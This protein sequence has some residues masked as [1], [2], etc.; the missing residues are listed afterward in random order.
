MSRK[1][2]VPKAQHD[3]L[4]SPAWVFALLSGGDPGVR[5]RGW[6]QMYQ[7]HLGAPTAAMLWQQHREALIAE[8]AAHGFEPYM[9]SG[10]RPSGAGFEA[11][12][13]QWLEANCY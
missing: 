11:W 7:Q 5:L 4:P 13:K 10:K 3:D 9:D 2:R 12:R 1:L 8:A 6:A